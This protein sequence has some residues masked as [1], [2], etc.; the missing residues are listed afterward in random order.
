MKILFLGPFNKSQKNI[1]DF[2]Q[3]D[4][5]HIVNLNTNIN[6]I[7]IDDDFDFLISYGYRFIINKK[8]LESIKICSLNLHISYLPWNKGA[9]PNFWS[10]AENTPRGV[11]IH[12]I[13]ENI[14][15]GPVIYRKKISYKKNDTLSSSYNKLLTSIE[16]LFFDKWQYLKNNKYEKKKINEK[17]SFHNSKDIQS[18]S[19]F[20]I[21]GWETKVSNIIGIAK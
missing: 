11:S 16:S 2:L 8:I 7:N 4:N 15:E 6:T 9:D 21:N 13:N 14:D 3:K 12:E 18:Y 20:L 19:H 5:N 17:G 1:I 10:F